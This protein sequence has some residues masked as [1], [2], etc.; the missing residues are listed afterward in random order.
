ME[1]E[2]RGKLG[3]VA[4]LKK[5]T[6]TKTPLQA[7][8]SSFSVTFEWDED[9]FGVPGAVIVKNLHH[10]QFFLKSLTLED[11]PGAGRVHFDCNSWVYPASSYKYDR[12]FFANQINI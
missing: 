12:I 1:K 2:N 10:S 7:V 6:M 11:V 5:W 8:E 9:G 4:Y 3:K